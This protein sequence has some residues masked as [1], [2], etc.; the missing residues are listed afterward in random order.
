MKII[1]MFIFHWLLKKNL[2]MSCKHY[3]GYGNL[4]INKNYCSGKNFELKTN[5]EARLEEKGFV[6]KTMDKTK[7]GYYYCKLVEEDKEIIYLTQ[8]GMRIF[9]K[10]EY[11]KDIFRFP[12]EAYLIRKVGCEVGLDN[13]GECVDVKILEKKSQ[14]CAGSMETKLW[15]GPSLSREYELMLG[16]GFRVEYSFCLNHFLGMKLYSG[17]CGDSGNK[18]FYLSRILNENG[19]RVF[20]GDSDDY[21]EELDRW[22][23]I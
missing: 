15:S 17:V 9:M 21:F 8:N 16:S 22:I 18:Y 12:D 3:G 23:G 11:G 14:K 7:Y 19:I 6:R 13:N 10:R 1:M 2:S 5:N 4:I 20:M